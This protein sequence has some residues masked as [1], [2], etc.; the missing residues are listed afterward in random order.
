M[1][2]KLGTQKGE[3]TDDFRFYFKGLRGYAKPDSLLGHKDV[4]QPTE[5]AYLENQVIIELTVKATGTD[6]ENSA[7]RG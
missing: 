5:F 7:T 4:Q 1:D 3:Q 2:K 6:W